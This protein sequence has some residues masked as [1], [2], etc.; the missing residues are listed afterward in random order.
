MQ[1]LE[2][3]K[4]L[5]KHLGGYQLPRDL[6]DDRRDRK[7]PEERTEDDII[8][9]HFNEDSLHSLKTVRFLKDF[10]RYKAAPDLE[11]P[12][13]S[14]IRTAEIF[15][16]QGIKNYYFHL[17]LN[18]PLLKGVDPYSP[19]LTEEQKVMILNECRENFW[20]F[21]R[22]VCKLRHDIHF[23]ANRGNISYIWTYLN[24][25]TTYMIMPRQQ[26]KLQRLSNKVRMADGSWGTLGTLRLG[27]KVKDPFGTDSVVIGLHPQGVKR[28]YRV[29]FS[30]GRSTEAG[31]EHLWTV[32]TV[33][34]GNNGNDLRED[35]TTEGIRSGLKLGNKYKVPLF[36][37][38]GGEGEPKL[39]PYMMGLLFQGTQE[40]DKIK[41]PI[42]LTEEIKSKIGNSRVF[43][44]DNNGYVE[45]LRG[46][47]RLNISVGLP[48]EY[49]E[50]S[51][52]NRTELLRA[53]LEV[54]KCKGKTGVIKAPNSYLRGQLVYLIRSM[55]GTAKADGLNVEFT[56]QGSPKNE[57]YFESI[58]YIGDEEAICIEVDSEEKLYL[59]DDFIV[60]HNT[61]SVQVINFWLTYIIGEGYK[62]HVITLKSDNRAQFIDAIKR[63][64]SSI[65]KYLINSTYKDKDSGT[66]LTYRAFGDDKVNT[67]TINVPQIGQD[68]AGDLGRGLTVGTTNY[69]EPGYINWIEDI[70]NGCAPSAL[71]EMENMRN[72]GLPHGIGYITTPNTT[73]HPSGDY[74][75]KKLMS[76]TEWREKFF[77]SFSESHLKHRLLRASPRQTTSPSVSMVYNY[78]QL[79]KD[80]EWVTRTIDELNLTLSKAKIDLLLMWVEDGEDRLFDDVTR[81]A[82]NNVKRPK[83]WSKEYIDSGLFVDF[84]VSQEEVIKMCSPD[85]NDHFLIGVDTSAAV[86][87]DACTVVIRSAK[88]GKNV[89]VGRYPMAFLDDIT[90][91]ILDLLVSFH[92]STLIIE[93]NFAHHMIDNL[94]ILLPAKGLDP[95]TKMFNSIYQEPVKYEK[96]FEAVRSIKPQHRSK[97]FYLKYKA[98]FGFNTT[99]SSRA[100]LYG[101]IQEAVAVTGYGINFDKLAD[102]LINLKLRNGRIDHDVK[103]NDDL[104][105][106]W[107][108]T[109][110]FAKLGNNKPL[111]GISSGI[112]LTDTRNLMNQANNKEDNVDPSMAALLENIKER[113][114]K[115]T[116]KLLSTNDNILAL[117]IEAEIHKLSSLL[118]PEAKRLLTIDTLLADAKLE[119]NKR[120]IHNRRR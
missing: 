113:I 56:L 4:K 114:N 79:G 81:E 50:T 84:F 46:Q 73:L 54:S 117:R 10:V 24:H 86:N 108:L 55:G 74:M 31:L 102:E 85:Y 98:H 49:I 115:L 67:L 59:T 29:T 45:S 1:N 42:K 23:R 48:A 96:E 82:I 8:I 33:E 15:R 66:Y 100:L 118:P 28:M 27:D 71:T 64:R 89:G 76:A 44:V 72:A 97:D 47:S 65:P 26:G 51:L 39:D 18:N 62:T 9:D 80:K 103:G 60:T 92:N 116:D 34:A 104:V 7:K 107:L 83:V 88:T 40:G 25:I 32:D 19:D 30:D 14:F 16:R 109:Y 120:M 77:D 91:V 119:R 11:T 106:A 63:I 95:F 58:E 75:Y 112:V 61:V 93:R 38:E 110:W 69:D 87:K 17:Q 52:E 12:N 3:A 20:Y 22:E 68:A 53:F 6:I 2:I 57:L 5:L 78:L 13:K 90:A 37:G 21:L 101:L 35:L 99:A 105:I 94:L 43:K 41:L 36:N 70:V 111:Y